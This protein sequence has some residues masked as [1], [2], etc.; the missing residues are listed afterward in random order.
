M[1]GFHF[2]V[3]ARDA[4]NFYFHSTAAR[5]DSAAAYFCFAVVDGHEADLD[6]DGTA[7]DFRAM[8]IDFCVADFHFHYGLAECEYLAADYV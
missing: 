8:A 2:D 1:N 5:G 3:A 6:F 7:V 4:E